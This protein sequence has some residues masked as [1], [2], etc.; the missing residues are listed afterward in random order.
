M[1]ILVVG[2]WGQL[3]SELLGQ[4]A[5]NNV[6]AVG[7]DVDEI[8]I[9]DADSAGRV[10]ARIQPSVVVNAAAYTNVDKAESEPERAYAVN[11]DGPGN[12]A[13]ICGNAGIPLVHIST[14]F[15]FDGRKSRPYTEDDPPGPLGVYGKSKADG[16]KAVQAHTSRF[17]I[18]RTSWLYSPHGHNF[19]K[20]ML[21]LGSE[22]RE[23]SVVADQQGS[24]TSAADFAEAVLR[25]V[26]RLGVSDDNRWGV[27]HYCGRGVTSWHGFA[28]EIFDIARRHGLQAVPSVIPISTRQYPTPAQRPGYSVL[29]CHRITR[30]FGIEPRPWTESLEKVVAGLVTGSRAGR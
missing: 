15:V 4:A 9:T 10:I 12:L 26:H 13:A 5:G 21:R 28:Q 17:I 18:I 20:T 27:Y 16:E 29:D 30:T 7:V 3:G 1:T 6:Q 19:V 8:D 23:I 24:P 11:C 22:K 25:V 2:A 14:D